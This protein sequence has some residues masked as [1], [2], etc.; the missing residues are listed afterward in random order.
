MEEK[1]VL[2]SDVHRLETLGIKPNVI[3]RIVCAR[4]SR[5][6]NVKHV[7]HVNRFPCGNVSRDQSCGKSDGRY[8]PS[9]GLFDDRPKRPRAHVRVRATRSEP[10]TFGGRRANQRLCSRIHAT[11]S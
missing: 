7:R 2:E 3:R 9:T 1:S 4:A 11:R 10:K 8:G 6:A 5:F